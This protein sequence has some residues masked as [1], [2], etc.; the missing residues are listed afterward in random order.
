MGSGVWWNTGKS[1]VVTPSSRMPSCIEAAARGYDSIQLTGSFSYFTFEL[2]DCR[3]HRL[4]LPTARQTWEH[5][6]PPS[7]MELRSGLP[8]PRY[9]PALSD[10][11]RA[12]WGGTLCACDTARPYINCAGG[13]R[14]AG[15]EQQPRKARNAL[16][17]S[18]HDVED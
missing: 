12:G 2:V 17:A 14:R 15:R 1:L 7:H 3:A 9:A 4:G 13:G 10:V 5:A 16:V 11:Q 6:C 8:S 18:E